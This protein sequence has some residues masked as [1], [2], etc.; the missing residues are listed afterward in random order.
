MGTSGNDA[1]AGALSDG[2]VARTL[3]GGAGHDELIATAASVLFGGSGNDTFSIDTAMIT[4]LQAAFGAGGNTSRLA[5][6]DGGGGI[7][8]IALSG[9]GLTLDLTLV[10]NQ[11]ASNPDG[12]SR[13]DSVERINI[14]GT[15]NNTLK[16]K[17]NDVLDMSAANVF[18]ATGRQQL[19]VLGDEGDQ[20]DL[21]DGTGTTGWTQRSDVTLTGT[22][23]GT[24]AVWDHTSLATIYVS[25]AVSVI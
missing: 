15:G 9:T 4:A 18:E 10:A 12:G 8:T 6:I 23:A 2:G 22:Y 1:G 17:V 16:L 25:S 21:A 14:T 7:D 20:V 3:V 11:A 13:I 19:M 24:Y 5:R